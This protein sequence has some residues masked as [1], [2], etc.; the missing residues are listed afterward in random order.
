M[1]LSIR[2]NQPCVFFSSHNMNKENH[3]SPPTGNKVIRYFNRPYEYL[4]L[5]FLNQRQH[6]IF[7]ASKPHIHPNTIIH[8]T[9]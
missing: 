5:L 2:E 9:P 6:S 1:K 4:N 3:F 7:L 8:E